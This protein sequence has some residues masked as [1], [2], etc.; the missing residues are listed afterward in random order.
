MKE[1]GDWPA[2]QHLLCRW[3][4]YEA[5]KRYCGEYFKRYPKGTQQN[6]MNRFITAFRDVVCAPTEPEMRT[7]WNLKIE[8][9]Q[10]PPEAVAYVRKEYYESP[11]AQQIMECF[12]FDSGNLHQT[13]TFT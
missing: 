12:V 9:G 6:E 11:K 3:H 2:V 8:G 10:F 7:A 13:T 4:V 5:I 1:R